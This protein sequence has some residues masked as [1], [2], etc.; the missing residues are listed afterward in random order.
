M[1]DFGGGLLIKIK[2]IFLLH[3]V[4]GVVDGGSVNI[5]LPIGLPQLTIPQQW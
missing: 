2:I 5:P 3:G 1:S 4:M